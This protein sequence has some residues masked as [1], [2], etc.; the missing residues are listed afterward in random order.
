MEH[1]KLYTRRSEGALSDQN[2]IEPR[3]TFNLCI[4]IKC[5]IMFKPAIEISV[6]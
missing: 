4:I 5:S 2:C 6:I 3:P 1:K